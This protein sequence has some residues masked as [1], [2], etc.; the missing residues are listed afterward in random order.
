MSQEFTAGYELTILLALA[1]RSLTDELHVRLA[2]LGFDDVRPNHGYA[3]QLLSFGPANI[4][5]LA[6]HLE[7]TKQAASQM[8]EY[9]EQHKYVI[10]QPDPNDK[11]GKLVGLTARGWECI[12]HT[13][14]IFS[15]LEAQW[16]ERLGNTRMAELRSDL[17]S[18]VLN[19]NGGVIPPLLRPI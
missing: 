18:L 9:L 4:N 12:R 6:A 17:R 13:E 2:Q 19:A 3:F 1:F 15:E 8:V 7:V 14:R 16:T 10:R 5:D 11:R